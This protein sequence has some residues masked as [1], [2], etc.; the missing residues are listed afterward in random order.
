MNQKPLIALVAAL[1]IVGAVFYFGLK[2][3]KGFSNNETAQDNGLISEDVR[4][5]KDGL[6]FVHSG[7]AVNVGVKAP[8]SILGS[9]QDPVPGFLVGQYVFIRLNDPDVMSKAR[10]VFENEWNFEIENEP[11]MPPTNDGV[12]SERFECKKEIISN[13]KYNVRKIYCFPGNYHYLILKGTNDG[14]FIDGGSHGYFSAEEEKKLTYILSE[15]QGVG[16]Q[17]MLKI[18]ESLEIK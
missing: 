5:D 10:D 13:T 1:A 2:N 14:L 8:N 16:D 18:I 11:T 15:E 17:A 4:Y 9:A 3:D 7:F 6:S 12:G